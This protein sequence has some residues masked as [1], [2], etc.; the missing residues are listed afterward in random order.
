MKSS[1]ELFPVALMR[2]EVVA[3][4]FMEDTYLLK[5]NNSPDSSVQI[6]LTRLGKYGQVEQSRGR[7][8]IL[9][10]GSF[11]NRGTWLSNDGKGLAAALNESGFDPWML[12][13]R[14]HGDSPVNQKYDQNNNQIYA[15]YDLP[16][17]NEFVLEQT[18]QKPVWCGHSS[19]GVCIATAL[20]AGDLDTGKAS[21]LIMF[22]SQVSRYPLSLRL[23]IIRTLAKF[24]AG[25]K[26]HIQSPKLGVEVEP[27]GIAKEFVRWASLFRGWR[28][29]KGKPYWHKLNKIETP[30]LAF[31][32]KKDPGDPAKHCKKLMNGFAGDKTYYFLAKEKGFSQDYNHSSMVVSEAAEKEVWPKAIEWLKN[33]K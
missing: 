14:G 23:P 16:A 24:I 32:A 15:K 29:E 10:H 31:G 17:V 33:L 22:G 5:P 27:K 1:S 12:E 26:K 9:V 18:N 4:R 2:A 3:D 6:A 8:V 28:P 13:L 7:P 25:T 30:V 19:G 11:S 21:G 20:A